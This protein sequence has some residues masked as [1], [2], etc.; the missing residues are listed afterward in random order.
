MT[1]TE[2]IRVVGKTRWRRFALVLVP[3][4]A[5]VAGLLFAAMS[6]V[7]AVSFTISGVGAKTAI[8]T[9]QTTTTDGNGKALYQY[10]IA[11]FSPA[12]AP[13]PQISTVIAGADLTNLC[14]SVSVG[15][16]TIT[17]TAGN[18]GTP[19]KATTLVVDAASL[20]ASSANFTNINIGQ[21]LSAF[22]N[23]TITQPIG[24]GANGNANTAPVPAGTFGQ[25]ATA[26]TLKDVRQVANGTQAASFTLPNL[27]VKFGTPCF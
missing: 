25:T 13:S 12:G 21:D 23:P 8:D 10:G 5:L 24:A 19:V 26:A 11:D 27:S 17:T 4:Y 9:L 1:D 2:E 18:A 22:S 7:L 3:A 14:Q 15:P 20:T 16:F 6:G